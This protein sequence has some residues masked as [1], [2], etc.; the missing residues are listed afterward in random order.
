MFLN[1][2]EAKELYNSEDGAMYKYVE[3]RLVDQNIKLLAVVPKYFG[4]IMATGEINNIDDPTAKKRN[5]DKSTTTKCF[6]KSLL[7]RLALAQL[8]YQQQNTFTAA[9]RC[10]RSCIRRWS[11]R[12]SMIM[13]NF[14]KQFIV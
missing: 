4:S 1:W 5:E 3:E 7:Q 6:L 10:C 11:G 2:D 12:T 9:D 13:V 8:H 14:V